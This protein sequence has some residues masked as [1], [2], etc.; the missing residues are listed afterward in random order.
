MHDF[1]VALALAL[2]LE[3]LL[4]AAFPTF[5]KRVIETILQSPEAQIRVIGLTTAII[6]LIVLVWLKM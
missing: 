5:M 2:V 3:G 1:F 6:G 4:Y